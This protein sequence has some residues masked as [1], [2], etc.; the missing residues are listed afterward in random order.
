MDQKLQSVAEI[1]LKFPVRVHRDTVENYEKQRGWPG[2]GA[3]MAEK[4]NIV[5]IEDEKL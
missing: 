5:I 3:F 2:W 1:P 4:G